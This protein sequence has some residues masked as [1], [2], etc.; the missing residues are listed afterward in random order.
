MQH[1]HWVTFVAD[2]KQDMTSF[3]YKKSQKNYR[4][5]LRFHVKLLVF[6]RLSGKMVAEAFHCTD[7]ESDHVADTALFSNFTIQSADEK[8]IITMHRVQ[9]A[10]EIVEHVKGQIH[11]GKA[12]V[13][14][15]EK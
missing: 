3:Q 15:T 11:D 12:S 9:K 8:V 13:V 7:Y 2:L 10:W 6:R 4:V 1:I 14:I 5:L